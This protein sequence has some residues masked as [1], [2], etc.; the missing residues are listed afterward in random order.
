[1]LN[2]LSSC[3][4]VTYSAMAMNELP[5]C[6]DA[7]YRVIVIRVSSITDLIIVSVQHGF[8]R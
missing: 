6:S 3:M 4:T 2:V 8:P 5:A 7:E 1:M